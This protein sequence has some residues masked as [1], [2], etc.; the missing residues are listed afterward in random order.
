MAQVRIVR[1]MATLVFSVVLIAVALYLSGPKQAIDSLKQFPL[2]SVAA[3]AGLLLLNLGLVSLRFSK[4]LAHFGLHLPFFAVWRA[5]VAGQLAGQF[6]ISLFGQVMG[7][8][9]ALRKYG[10]APLL[11]SSITGYERAIQLVVS[12]LVCI[13]G[14][15]IFMDGTLAVD[16]IDIAT[17]CEISIAICAAFGLGLYLWR[18][19]FESRFLSSVVT[20]KNITDAFGLA[21]IS[22]VAQLLVLMTFVVGIRFYLPSATYLELFAATAIVS[23]AASLPISVNGWGLREVAAIYI[24]GKLGVPSS[25]ALA[26]SLLVGVSSTAII[27][28]VAPTII[29]RTQASAVLDF[30][31]RTLGEAASK[32]A[33]EKTAVWVLTTV[34]TV[35]V[36]FQLH[37]SLPGGLINLN[38]ADPF[39][40]L[41]IAGV[42]SHILATRHLP[43]W[44]VPGFNRI[45]IGITLF[46]G[47]AF[48]IGA[49]KIGVTQ[50]ALAGR[51]IGWLILLGYLSLGWQL[52]AYLGRQG[53]RRLTTSLSATIGVIVIVQ[54]LLRWIA[55]H[56]LAPIENLTPNFEGY[57]GNRNAFAFQ[58]IVC[59]ILMLVH[60][61]AF[62]RHALKK[63]PLVFVLLHALLLAGLCFSAS[64]AG[65]IVEGGILLVAYALR[66]ASREM[67]WRTI[68]WAAILW[69]V[70]QI[71]LIDMALDVLL[72]VAD[73]FPLLDGPWLHRCIEWRSGVIQSRIQAGFSNEFSNMERMQSILHGLALWRESPVFG[74]GLGVAIQDSISLSSRPLVIHSTPIWILVE[75]GI[76]GFSGAVAAVWCFIKMFKRAGIRNLRNRILLL[77]LLAFS[78]F[79]LV[80]EIFYQRIFWLV[81]GV[82]IATY[83]NNGSFDR[84][85]GAASRV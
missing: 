31:A 59:S 36:C 54:I 55:Q 70:P 2:S 60:S 82:A 23:F 49:I 85:S 79:G 50:W 47:L 6:F 48:T 46:L 67:I 81:L 17:L 19:R 33:H 75:F 64:R 44:E 63:P 32:G 57:A 61:E 80:H 24:F 30:S 39:A 56:G 28:L 52:Y 4:V 51:V 41:A 29:R 62:S 16:F 69:A 72:W 74:V 42:A 71:P 26:V 83:M 73:Q 38:L 21:S 43:A 35:L 11:I 84:K 27:F 40:L 9:A 77:L 13:L 76:A 18:S 20:R 8:H 53:A 22:L 78:I 14:L 12:G 66:L 68:I 5:S 7:R 37:V 15:V 34:A 3:I 45:L 10:V 1:R 25:D 65:L 58:L